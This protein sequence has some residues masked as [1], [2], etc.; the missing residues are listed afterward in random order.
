MIFARRQAVPYAESP[1]M[2]TF[3]PLGVHL[4]LGWEVALPIRLYGPV[5]ITNGFNGYAGYVQQGILGR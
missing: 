1:E 3:C 4:F 5:R 2:D